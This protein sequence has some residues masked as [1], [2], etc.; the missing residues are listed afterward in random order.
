MITAV[1]L[2]LVLAEA[3]WSLTLWPSREPA[4]QP[5]SQPACLP[6]SQSN[7]PMSAIATQRDL[8]LDIKVFPLFAANYLTYV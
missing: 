6:A 7:V 4:S 8:E 3:D 5:A 1:H 2:V